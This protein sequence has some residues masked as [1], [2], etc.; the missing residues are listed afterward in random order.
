VSPEA[1]VAALKDLLAARLPDLTLSEQAVAA[2]YDKYAPDAFSLMDR[3]YI[4]R[5]HPLELWLLDYLR[6]H[7]A[8]TASETI[9]A[10]AAE[11]QEVYRWLFKTSRRNAQDKRIASLLEL[12]AFL[13]IQRGWERLG[14]PFASVT[15]SLASAIGASGDRP[16]ALAELMG[17]IVN[18][19]ARRPTLLVDRLDFASGTPYETRLSYAEGTDQQVLAPEIAA[20]VRG[21]LTDVV[22][23]GTARG[24]LETMRRGGS[25]HVV[26]GKTGTGDHRYDTF[27]PGGRLIESR[28]VNRAATFVFQIDDRFFGTVTAYVPGR[29]AARYQFTSA[30]PVRL[31]GILMPT[32][33]PLLDA[34]AR[35]PVRATAAAPTGA[36]SR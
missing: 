23:E 15:P 20:V 14:Y 28:V 25:K 19:G 32:L 33:A 16:A 11:R 34:P 18:G 17:I 35:A 3:G 21:A 5:V 26:G 31:L 13:L 9:S 4:A 22:T 8:A 7:P 2:L 29:E 10:S 24:L 12:E 36:T 27:A 30:L 6:A 1:D